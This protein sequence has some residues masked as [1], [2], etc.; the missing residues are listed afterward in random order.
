M[1]LGCEFLLLDMDT[2]V[3]AARE[4]HRYIGSS[5]S[6]ITSQFGSFSPSSS[7]RGMNYRA[8]NSDVAFM[9]SLPNKYFTIDGYSEAKSPSYSPETSKKIKRST[10]IPINRKPAPKEVAFTTDL[11]HSEL[12]ARPADTKYAPKGSPCATDLSRSELWAGPAYTNSPPPSSL[13]IPK[14][15]LRERRDRRP[16]LFAVL[17]LISE[18]QLMPPFLYP[19]TTATLARRGRLYAAPPSPVILLFRPLSGSSTM[20]RCALAPAQ[21]WCLFLQ[22][23]STNIA[24]CPIVSAPSIAMYYCWVLPTAKRESTQRDLGPQRAT[25]LTIA[26]HPSGYESPSDRE[27]PSTTTAFGEYYS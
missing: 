14:F 24:G 9:Q 23:V 5:K 11:F 1:A 25:Q 15:S 8:F 19:V 21:I 27:P 7:F 18:R 16:P 17:V 20:Q 3:S 2:I 4:C 6:R 12:C 10:S 22:V 13:P 26:G